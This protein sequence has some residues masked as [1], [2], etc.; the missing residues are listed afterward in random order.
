MYRLMQETLLQNI[1]WRMCTIPDY[2]CVKPPL[3]SAAESP[4]QPRH[5]AP[6]A[7][8]LGSIPEQSTTRQG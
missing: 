3:N 6:G 2:K 1:Y 5:Q 4:A 8:E 7:G